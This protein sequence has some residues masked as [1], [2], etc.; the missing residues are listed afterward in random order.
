V[1]A[2]RRWEERQAHGEALGWRRGQEGEGVEGNAEIATRCLATAEFR[3]RSGLIVEHARALVQVRCTDWNVGGSKR[4]DRCQGQRLRGVYLHT[5]YWMGLMV[6]QAASAH[7]PAPHEV[8]RPV[9]SI[10]IPTLRARCQRGGVE[11]LSC[12]DRCWAASRAIFPS[13]TRRPACRKGVA[14]GRCR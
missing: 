8:R 3:W 11:H 10:R 13:A 4:R 2:D 14:P 9:W 7:A 5:R 12:H 6:R 1:A